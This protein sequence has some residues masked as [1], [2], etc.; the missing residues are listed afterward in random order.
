M[1]DKLEDSLCK[2][3]SHDWSW[4]GSGEVERPRCKRC[5]T[6]FIEWADAHGLFRPDAKGIRWKETDSGD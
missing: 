2:V 1:A 5:K 4:T 6:D 3:F